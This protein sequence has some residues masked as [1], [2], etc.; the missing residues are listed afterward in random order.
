MLDILRT[1]G[2]LPGVSKAKAVLEPQAGGLTIGSK[3]PSRGRRCRTPCKRMILP[4]KNGPRQSGVGII[5]GNV[6]E[7]IENG[8][9][10]GCRG[11][12][13][14]KVAGKGVSYSYNGI[15]L[16]IEEVG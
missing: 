14:A 9:G 3:Q 12:E 6:Q 1:K 13:R 2:A 15:P 8:E 10:R 7:W 16:C 5:I 11:R 4:P